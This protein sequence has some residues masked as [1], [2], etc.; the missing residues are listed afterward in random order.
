[1]E[2]FEEWIKDDNCK[3]LGKKCDHHKCCCPGSYCDCDAKS[4]VGVCNVL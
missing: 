4:G 2:F 1:M 3:G